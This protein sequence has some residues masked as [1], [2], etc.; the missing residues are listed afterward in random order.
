M[1]RDPSLLDGARAAAAEAVR[2]APEEPLGHVAA[3]YP[4]YLARADSRSLLAELNE[5]QSK[6][7][8]IPEFFWLR[9][10][11]YEN[12]G[13]WEEALADRS[14]VV[15]L[16][17]R[18]VPALLG[19]AHGYEVLRRYAEAAALY[20][21]AV[22]LEPNDAGTLVHSATLP[23]FDSGDV[24]QLRALEPRML[25]GELPV[26]PVV[27]AAAMYARDYDAVFRLWSLVP[28]SPPAS[29]MSYARLLQLGLA[30]SFAGRDEEAQRAFSTAREFIEERLA[31]ARGAPAPWLDIALAQALRG[32]GER[33]AAI[34]RVTGALA[35]LVVLP[36]EL[37]V[38]LR[39]DAATLLAHAGAVDKAIAE[40]DTYLSGPGVWS[41]EG[42]VTQRVLDG[43]RDDPRWAELVRKHRRADAALA[44]TARDDGR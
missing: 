23:L 3:A 22:E 28:E 8:R 14:Q 5:V 36:P 26:A 18:N 43:I 1:S 2:L 9:A 34:E 30:Y 40:F 42:L 7:Q 39:L 10:D 12:L 4:A 38:N 17:P 19:N 35:D 33:E 44:S 20:R 37:A 15:A 29:D 16:D 11:L 24:R 13:L 27:I 25:A 41:I 6:S 31:A 21:R 32:L